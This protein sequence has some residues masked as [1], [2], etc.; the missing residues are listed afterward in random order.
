MRPCKRIE[1]VN[2]I[3]LYVAIFQQKFINMTIT[4][5]MDMDSRKTQY[6][7]SAYCTNWKQ[8]NRGTGIL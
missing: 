1:V 4:L 3:V 7:H 6:S 8:C 2:G 5:M